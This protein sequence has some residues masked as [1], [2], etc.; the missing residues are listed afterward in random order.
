[1]KTLFLQFADEGEATAMLAP[2]I[3][4]G[5]V[6]DVIGVISVAAGETI[7]TPDGLVPEMAPL[8]GWFVNVLGMTLPDDLQPFEIFPESPVRVFGT[9]EPRPATV[10]TSCTR[11]QGLLAL[12]AYDHR[13]ADIEALIAAIPDEMDREAAMIDY[14]AATWERSNPFLQQMWAAL[15][16]EHQQ[17]D[18]VFRMAVTL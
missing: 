17:L 18:E 12:L 1:M 2:F 11:R 3:D 9:P 5:M 14:E 8:P 13:R 7:D 10:P 16:G 15:G 6:I 4:A